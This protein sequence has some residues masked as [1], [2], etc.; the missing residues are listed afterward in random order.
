[1]ALILDNVLAELESV[2]AD[3]GYP[4]DWAVSI[5]E[6]RLRSKF[7]DNDNNVLEFQL[8]PKSPNEILENVTS[9]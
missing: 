6:A 7:A 2:A 1:M 8:Q 5:I 4:V 3:F 9:S